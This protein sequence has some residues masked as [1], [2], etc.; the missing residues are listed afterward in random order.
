MIL[1]SFNIKEPISAHVDKLNNKQHSGTE[2]K[3]SN[4]NLES[5]VYQ[6]Y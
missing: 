2:K 6:E 3:T 5:T 1:I 4:K